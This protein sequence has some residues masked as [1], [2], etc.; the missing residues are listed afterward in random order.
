[1][2]EVVAKL[3]GRVDMIAELKKQFELESTLQIV[4]YIDMNEEKSTPTLGH[5]IRTI[6][7]LY[8]TQTETDVDIYRYNS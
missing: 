2:K 4:L 7:F 8:A 3:E 6:S 1:V 5:D